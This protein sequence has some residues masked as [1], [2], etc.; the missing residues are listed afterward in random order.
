MSADSQQHCAH[1]VARARREQWTNAHSVVLLNNSVQC[2]TLPPGSL[3]LLV[4]FTQD[5]ALPSR[6]LLQY[7]QRTGQPWIGDINVLLAEVLQAEAA[8]AAANKP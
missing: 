4:R 1:N 6:T 3:P 7:K 2:T 5:P 8:A